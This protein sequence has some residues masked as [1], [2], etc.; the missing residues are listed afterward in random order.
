M[1]VKV[2]HEVLREEIKL[3]NF[4]EKLIRYFCQFLSK[5]KLF[6]HNMVYVCIPYMALQSNL[7]HC[8]V[9]LTV[10]EEGIT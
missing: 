6:P 2:I 5:F 7:K 8:K 10:I 1:N 9:N 4:K 3:N